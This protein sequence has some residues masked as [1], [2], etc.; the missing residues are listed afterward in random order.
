[1]Q[2]CVEVQGS[3]VWSISC[4]HIKC[5]AKLA[6]RHQSR[7]YAVARDATL[8]IPKLCA[9]N[10]EEVTLW[11]PIRKRN[12]WFTVLLQ[13][14]SGPVYREQS[15]K[16]EHQRGVFRKPSNDVIGVEQPC[17][18]TLTDLDALYLAVEQIPVK[19]C[20]NTTVFGL[21]LRIYMVLPCFVC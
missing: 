4:S 16:S 7:F 10:Q 19:C 13:H 21:V 8:N 11:L 3:S 5:V 17:K 14:S 2:L 18:A 9:G 6:A 1:M 15:Q 12:T 20:R